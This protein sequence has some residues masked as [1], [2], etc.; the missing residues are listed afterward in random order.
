MRPQR[1]QRQCTVE[2]L[3][4]VQGGRVEALLQARESHVLAKHL[5][6]AVCWSYSREVS[7]KFTL[8]LKSYSQGPV[9]D[10]MGQGV[11]D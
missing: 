6:S 2:V 10:A 4:I 8:K 1:Q 3:H 5:P 9:L 11:A 7:N